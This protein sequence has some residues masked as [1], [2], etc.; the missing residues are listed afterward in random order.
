MT[1]DRRWPEDER[2]TAFE[3]GSP[4]LDDHRPGFVDRKVREPDEEGQVRFPRKSK[5]SDV[6]RESLAAR[7]ARAQRGA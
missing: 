1:S 7:I 3:P 5:Q 2:N 6:P 4:P